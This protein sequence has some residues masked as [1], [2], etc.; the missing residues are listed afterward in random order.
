VDLAL[1]E[2]FRDPGATEPMRR[3]RRHVLEHPLD[4][5]ARAAYAA[6][7]MA[8]AP[9]L[10]VRSAAAFHARTAARAAPVTVP[11]VRQAALILAGS[12]AKD[13]AVRWNRHLFEFAPAEAAGLLR[14]LEGGLTDSD[15]L[16][17]VGERP[18]AATAWGRDLLERGRRSDAESWFR[19]AVERD[20]ASL[21]AR[22]LLA[23][24]RAAR[25]DWAGVRELLEAPIPDEPRT[26]RLRAVAGRAYAAEGRR[27][28]AAREVARA[29]DL[30][31]ED[32]DVLAE[33]AEAEI[34]LGRIEVARNLLRTASHLARA[35][36]QRLGILVRIARLEDESGRPAEALRAWRRVLEADPENR[37]A[38]RRLEALVGFTPATGS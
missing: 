31:P 22:T 38:R 32:A 35:D 15:V 36:R 17:A 18:E 9:G 16:L 5:R 13:E 1:Q 37:E 23:T 14:E 26:A 4:G 25:S 30:A 8:L 20:P 19:A 3:L 12:G 24:M 21:D 34:S 6:G 2:G 10:E 7:I 27:T 29:L 33:V 11:V 28:E